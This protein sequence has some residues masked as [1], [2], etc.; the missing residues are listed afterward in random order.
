MRV[1]R[2][3]AAIV[4]VGIAALL[5]VQ[6]ANVNPANTSEVGNPKLCGHLVDGRTHTPAQGA[7][8]R[9]YQA[10]L[11]NTG[12]APA[13]DSTSTDRTGLYRFDSLAEG[14]YSVEGK[15]VD[16]QDTLF[17]YRPMVIFIAS[18]DIGYDT[19]QLPGSIKGRVVVSGENVKNI[20]CY[21]PGT[22]YIAITDS[23]GSF[24]ITGIPAGTYPLSFTSAKFNDTTVYGL[25]VLP[26]IETDIGNIVLVLD[27]SKNEHDVWGVFDTTTD[28]RKVRR[29]EARVSGDN[30]PADSPRVYS[31]DWRSD[32]AGYSGFIYLPTNGLFWKV[33][34]WVYDSLD[35]RM[36]AFQIP[37][38][39][40]SGDIQFP[41]FG[42]CN[43]IPVV[44]LNDTIV[45][46]NDSVRLYPIITKLAD[47][48]IVSWAWDIGNTGTFITSAQDTMIIAPN[49]SAELA[50]VFR[51]TDI[52]GNRA[53][54]VTHIAVVKDPPVATVGGDT[55]VSINDSFTVRGSGTDRYG[56]VVNYRYDT[57]GDG[58]FEDSTTSSGA[59]R[60]KARSS[61]GTVHVILQVEDD[62]GN[63]TNDTMVLRVILDPPKANAG[64]DTTVNPADS[65]S[66][67]CSGS[68]VYGSIVKYRLDPDNDGV[69]EDSSTSPGDRRL[70]APLTEGNYAVVLQ[71]EDDDGNR[72]NDTMVV[73]VFVHGLMAYWSFDSSSTSTYYDVT[74]HGY[75]AVATGT[76][77]GLAAGVQGQ[78]M[79]CSGG[80]FEVTAAHSSSDFNFTKYTIECWIYCA[81]IPT[82]SA[83]IFNNN[84]CEASG[85]SANGYNVAV[86]AEGRVVLCQST[87][88]G[89]SWVGAI[90]S[91]AL[92]PVTWYH[93]AC[94]NDSTS[95]KVYINGSLSDN[96]SYVGTYPLPGTDARI[97]C[98]RR[99][100]GNMYYPFDGMIDELKLYNCA[101]SADTIAAH[102]SANHP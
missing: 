39:R 68:D 65:F 60:A 23:T 1:M 37:I 90:S 87:S 54:A 22:S 78:A 63:N 40:S 4:T 46:I 14:I 88:S 79:S 71:V 5:T 33:A 51:V 47:D 18:K 11:N 42:P 21:I 93:I 57:N 85:G 73:H 55:T 45:S 34:V 25:N 76:G 41:S 29:L 30:I 26:N 96:L 52:F 74:G 31:L 62:D 35:H 24:R 27:R 49:D 77:V 43:G 100:D 17:M 80:N 56:K 48:S 82:G 53:T 6:C 32:V 12:G 10:Y 72:S 66:V 75:D 94:V 83:T 91:T 89:G 9:L 16:G 102:Y 99:Q 81:V 8:V 84:Y 15:Q 38:N 7:T 3:R 59:K 44:V 86:N 101:L 97:G 64:K 67:H 92:A 20:T 2:W 61:P 13:L 70:M 36:G 28:Y 98:Q 50:C 19:L 69:F 58:L 95:L